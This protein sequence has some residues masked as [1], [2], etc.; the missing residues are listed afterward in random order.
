MFELHLLGHTCTLLG[1][2]SSHVW[3]HS[4]LLGQAV[5]DSD[6]VRRRSEAHHTRVH[7]ANLDAHQTRTTQSSTHPICVHTQTH[8]LSPNSPNTHH[9]VVDPGAI[10]RSRLRQARSVSEHRV[11]KR[12][13]IAPRRIIHM[14]AGWHP[15]AKIV[16]GARKVG[17]L[18]GAR[19]RGV[20]SADENAGDAG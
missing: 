4:R 1:H 2:T 14:R 12:V 8:K 3:A 7:D 5:M 20:W 11:Q 10:R 16:D 9:T 6:Y 15:D 17:V 13:R 19:G 18:A